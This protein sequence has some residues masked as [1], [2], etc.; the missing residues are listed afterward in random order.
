MGRRGG[1]P[2]TPPLAFKQDVPEVGRLVAQRASAPGTFGGGE[3]TPLLPYHAQGREVVGALR[4]RLS[5][6]PGN[7]PVHSTDGA[8]PCILLGDTAVSRGLEKP[9]QS[10]LDL[11]LSG[12]AG[13]HD[14]SVFLKLPEARASEAPFGKPPGGLDAKVLE[15]RD[16]GRDRP[17]DQGPTLGRLLQLAPSD[18]P[19]AAVLVGHGLREEELVQSA[20][21]LQDHRPERVAAI[22]FP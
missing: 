19:E 8:S 7:R 21:V 20:P 4:L 1:A 6:F 2:S 12:E 13:L 5:Q 10:F 11:M 9:A 22:A 15:V 18:L 16:H 3:E 17:F 14:D